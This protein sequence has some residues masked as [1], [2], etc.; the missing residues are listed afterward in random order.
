[1]VVVSWNQASAILTFQIGGLATAPAA[2]TL[3]LPAVSFAAVEIPDVGAA[4]AVS[5]SE[6]QRL[7]GQAPQPLAS[8]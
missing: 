2:T 5:Y 4:S 6:T 3:T 8:P 1:M 7:A